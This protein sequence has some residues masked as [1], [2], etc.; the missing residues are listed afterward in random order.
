LQ[1]LGADALL[2]IENGSSE[3]TI[4]PAFARFIHQGVGEHDPAR[5]RDDALAYLARTN[6]KSTGSR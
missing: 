6:L 2:T 4:D 3:R 5:L 1:R